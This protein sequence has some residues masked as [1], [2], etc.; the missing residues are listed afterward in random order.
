[1]DHFTEEI[2]TLLTKAGCDD[3]NKFSTS[4]G[5][6]YV[7]GTFY[8]KPIMISKSTHN[9]YILT[10]DNVYVIACQDDYKDVVLGLEKLIE[11]KNNPNYTIQSNSLA[12]FMRNLNQKV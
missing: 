5:T 6:K 12:L 9:S 3:V 10:V 8:N 11:N 1:M 2:A 7:S 4:L